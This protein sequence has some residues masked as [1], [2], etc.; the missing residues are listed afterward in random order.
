MW[1]ELSMKQ[2]TLKELYPDHFSLNPAPCS[3]NPEKGFTLLELVVSIAILSLVMVMIYGSLSMGSRAW[4]K[5]EEDIERIQRMRV[6]MNLLSRE[7]KSAFPYKV[8]PSELDTHKEFY[9]FEGKKDSISFVSTVPL[10]GGR[11]GLSWLSFWV[12]GE[13]GLVVVERDA[14]RSDIFKERNSMDK[15]EIEVLDANVASMKLEYYELKSGKEEGEG[16]GDW[17]E[18]WDP[19]EERTLPH[20]V[21]IALT[22]EEEGK[23]E[24][25]EEE[26]YERELII[27]LMIH[28]KA[29]RGRRGRRSDLE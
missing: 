23:R 11:G 12:E 8:T 26:V 3:L 4:E 25:D 18:Y 13:E 22:F 6:V 7:I 15:D 10:K 1:L 14:L 5:G 24:G 9:A 28:T 20:A 16:E 29:L 17:R 27:P 21:K 19:E 2:E